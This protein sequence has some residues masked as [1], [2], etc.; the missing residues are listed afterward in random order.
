MNQKYKR[1][2]SF[3]VADS[4]SAFTI[5]IK[6]V[7][8]SMDRRGCFISAQPLL[9]PFHDHS[10]M[11]QQIHTQNESLPFMI[12]FLIFRARFHINTMFHFPIVIIRFQ[13]S[14][15][16]NSRIK[17]FWVLKSLW[18]RACKSFLRSGQWEKW[19]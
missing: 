12:L 6:L 16:F 4:F 11:C 8:R 1:K 5:S 2:V 3:C 15:Y 10:T 7:H 9:K 17:T 14:L 18:H 19:Y 13:E